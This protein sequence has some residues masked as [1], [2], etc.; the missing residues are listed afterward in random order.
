MIKAYSQ[1]LSPPY[2]GLVQIAESERARAITMDGNNWEIHF[3]Q[4]TNSRRVASIR[5]SELP[6]ISQQGTHNRHDIDERILE[7]TA[8]L[9]EASLPFPAADEYEYWLLDP[10]DDSA[11]SVATGS[12]VLDE[13][14]H[15]VQPKHHQHDHKD[16]PVDRTVTP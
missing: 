16:R 1:R 15:N 12:V 4:G 13:L 3:L 7:L 11:I 2:S 9:C 10:K 5:H 14:Q 6:R 8:F